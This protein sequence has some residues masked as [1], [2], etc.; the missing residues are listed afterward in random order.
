MLIPS[1]LL[2]EVVKS[3]VA[4]EQLENWIMGEVQKGA[5]LPGLYPPNAE[6]LAR[7]KAETGG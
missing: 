4:Q 5:E 3:A 6:N 2:D 1:A 7:Y